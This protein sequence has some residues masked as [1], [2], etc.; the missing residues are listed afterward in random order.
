MW[1]RV[2]YDKVQNGMIGKE[3]E[4]GEKIQCDKCGLTIDED[5]GWMLSINSWPDFYLFKRWE[6][7]LCPECKEIV[8][9]AIVNLGITFRYT[10]E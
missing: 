4:M 9:L 3:S 8:V 6:A 1:E 10:G 7:Y 2:W 5:G